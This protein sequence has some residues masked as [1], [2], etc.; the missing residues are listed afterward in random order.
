LVYPF[1][2]GIKPGLQ[3]DFGAITEMTGY[4]LGRA[5]IIELL[6]ELATSSKNEGVRVKACITLNE[7]HRGTGGENCIVEI[8]KND[9]LV[10][11]EHRRVLE[12]EMHKVA[13]SNALVESVLR[14]GSVQSISTWAYSSNPGEIRRFLHVLARHPNRR[15]ADLARGDLKRFE[16]NGFAQ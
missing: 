9:P 8:L 6:S 15:I 14:D 16:R 4:R 2:N 5:R 13:E 12:E 3:I 1:E 7:T 11:A 10:D